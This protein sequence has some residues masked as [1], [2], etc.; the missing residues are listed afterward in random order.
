MQTPTQDQIDAAARVIW[1]DYCGR[2]TG[3]RFDDADDREVIKIQVRATAKAAIKA[4]FA[5]S[6]ELSN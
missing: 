5:C 6:S 2:F 1:D 3:S 4:A